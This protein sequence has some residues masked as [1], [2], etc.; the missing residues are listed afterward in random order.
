[1]SLVPK[2]TSYHN[3]EPNLLLEG[4]VSLVPKIAPYHNK[5]SPF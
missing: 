3:K 4:A 5:F 2:M 1:M